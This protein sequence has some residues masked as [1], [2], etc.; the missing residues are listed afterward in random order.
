MR[1]KT[2]ENNS[3]LYLY[4]YGKVT[5]S[6]YLLFK[7]EIELVDII[8][9][10]KNSRINQRSILLKQEFV[11]LLLKIK[12]MH[13]NAYIVSIPSSRVNNFN[14]MIDCI[15]FEQNNDDTRV[16]E[17]IYNI[18]SAHLSGHTDEHYQEFK[19]SLRINHVDY[20]EIILIDDICTSGR[21]IDICRHLLEASG[22]NVVDILV[23]GKTISYTN[24][25]VGS[26]ILEIV[27]TVRENDYR[28]SLKFNNGGY[29]RVKDN[30]GFMYAFQH[31][32]GFLDYPDVNPINVQSLPNSTS[33]LVKVFKP[34]SNK[35]FKAVRIT[36][37]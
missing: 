20:T 13:P 32:T 36:F 34:N 37:K 3:V 12:L 28:I 22:K 10:F 11:N 6:E 9:D 1:Y 8:Q 23:V 29:F 17:R 30:T 25:D 4:D 7:N 26:H 5:R 24:L 19:E 14:R 21:T 33:V 35:D 31:G 16:L 2:A 27:D 15:A 18:D